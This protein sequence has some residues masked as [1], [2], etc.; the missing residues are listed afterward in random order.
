MDEALKDYMNRLVE[1]TQGTNDELSSIKGS[2]ED[3]LG[4]V[5]EL[6]ELVDKLK[7]E[8]NKLSRKV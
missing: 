3:L 8:V 6:T 4:V 5:E 7:D 1:N 2:I